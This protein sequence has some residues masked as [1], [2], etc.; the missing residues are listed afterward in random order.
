[1]Y[2]HSLDPHSNSFSKSLAEC[3]GFAHLQRENLT[4]RQRCEGC[5]RAKGLGNA[6]MK[7]KVLNEPKLR[8]SIW[9]Q[10]L[11]PYKKQT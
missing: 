9:E 7:N 11:L 4:T 3:L 6:C 2:A 10:E 5:I 1:M 8:H